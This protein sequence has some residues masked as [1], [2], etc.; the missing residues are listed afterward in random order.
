M[1]QQHVHLSAVPGVLI[2]HALV[3][4]HPQLGLGQA[5]QDAVPVVLVAVECQS[6]LPVNALQQLHVGLQLAVM[7][8]HDLALA[9][10][11]RPVAELQEFPG[12]DPGG[13]SGD[14]V[15]VNLQQQVTLKL[16]IGLFGLA[17][18]Q[19]GDLMGDVFRQLQ[20]VL[21]FHGDANI[22]DGG[23]HGALCPVLCFI[24]EN[25]GP[26]PL[27]RVKVLVPVGPQRGPQTCPT[28]QEIH[29]GP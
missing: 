16:L 7:H 19:D 21:R 4:P 27:V 10:V 28:V 18:Q 6:G 23:Q 24:A 25:L 3:D 8:R 20:V 17:V 5:L 14:D 2:L 22:S 12:E 26:A 9:A 1:H 15:F 11:H 29:L 13:A